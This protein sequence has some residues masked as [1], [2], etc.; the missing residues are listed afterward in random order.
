MNN[1]N[2]KFLDRFDKNSN[3]YQLICELSERV[4]NLFATSISSGSSGKEDDLVEI[5]I[6]EKLI[7]PQEVDENFNFEEKKE[8][9]S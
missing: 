2:L 5:V 9:I 8:Q 6:E 4:H 3:I 1:I 7:S